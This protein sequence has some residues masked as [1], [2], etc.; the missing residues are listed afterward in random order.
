ME[1]R[2]WNLR[3]ELQKL[4]QK[5]VLQFEIFSVVRNLDDLAA[6]GRK[7]L[8]RNRI[9]RNTTHGVLPNAFQTLRLHELY[10][11]YADEFS[12][13]D[14][15]DAIEILLGE[16]ETER[17]RYYPLSETAQHLKRVQESLIDL[18]AS[19]R[20]IRT[21]VPLGGLRVDRHFETLLYEGGLR[22]L[23]KKI[24]S[25]A[26]NESGLLAVRET[27]IA[28]LKHLPPHRLRVVV[29]LLHLLLNFRDSR[30]KEDRKL[31]TIVVN[32]TLCA[33]LDSMPYDTS[34]QRKEILFSPILTEKQQDKLDELLAHQ[35]DARY[36]QGRPRSDPPARVSPYERMRDEPKSY[37]LMRRPYN[38]GD[39]EDRREEKPCSLSPRKRSPV[40]QRKTENPWELSPQIRRPYPR[41]RREVEKSEEPRKSWHVR[42][43]P[44]AKEGPYQPSSG[45]RSIPHFPTVFS[46]IPAASDRRPHT[47]REKDREEFD[48]DACDT[49][50]WSSR[51]HSDK[52]VTSAEKMAIALGFN[53]EDRHLHVSELQRLSEIKMLENTHRRK[54]AEW[55][56]LQNNEE[57]R[58]KRTRG[59]I[60]SAMV[61]KSRPDEIPLTPIQ[62]LLA[63]AKK[64]TTIRSHWE[65][66]SNLM[67][68]EDQRSVDREKRSSSEPR[69]RTSAPR[70][71]HRY[72]HRSIVSA[73]RY[74]EQI[75]A[76][77]FRY[78]PQIVSSDWRD[79]PAYTKAVPCGMEHD[80][81][82][83][84]R[85]RSSLLKFESSISSGI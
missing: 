68:E 64:R 74:D 11:V 83:V 34:K 43:P 62:K 82:A 37:P 29:E 5:R 76:N 75:V 4:Q 12:D 72:D 3:L 41:E 15:E 21:V 16:M 20:G 57:E 50:P 33:G 30:Y 18:I 14:M 49:L 51:L 47:A 66:G 31:T 27:L 55:K 52:E 2:A 70:D 77:D 84:A 44:L 80:R 65:R 19:T 10:G 56:H 17:W 36:P 42:N 24:H 54:E 85:F 69:I 78:E 63:L 23:W 39:H 9:Y 60:E 79:Q 28:T 26:A 48:T 81:S 1:T 25:L 58:A 32:A 67:Q 61:G 53:D 59:G 71:D 46:A 22:D 13:M 40:E 45:S 73:P 8:R 6:L 35:Y 38:L 7:I